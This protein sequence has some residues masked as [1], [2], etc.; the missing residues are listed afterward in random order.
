MQD[1]IRELMSGPLID[2]TTTALDVLLHLLFAF[3]L[4][5]L[6]A[7]V[8][9]WTHHGVSYSRSNVQTLVL[10]ALV[11]TAVMLAVGNNLA[12]AFGL[13]GALALVRFRTPVKDARDTAFLFISVG[14]GVAVGS[15]NLVLAAV[16]TV[17]LC[18]VAFYMART[19]FG[20]RL[21]HDGVLRFAMPAT[22]RE[23]ADLHRV[24]DYY[25]RGFSLIHLRET[26]DR[27]TM[28]FSYQVKLHDPRASVGLLT[29]LQQVPGLR[30]ANLLMQNEDVEV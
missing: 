23:N 19:R 29:D 14:I 27:E 3:V 4:G 21:D 6:V 28:E 26:G 12:R 16:A 11:V 17:F 13:F 15:R 24:L 8:Y 9:T 22:D 30:A 5:Q 20:T 18:A 25:C 1:L 2:E 7:W 10:L